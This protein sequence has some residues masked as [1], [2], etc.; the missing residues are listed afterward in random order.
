MQVAN[1]YI[2]SQFGSSV[3]SYVSS[4]LSSAGS[5]AAIGT[6]IAPG[7]GT[8]VGAALGGLGGLLTAHTEQYAEQDDVFKSYVQDAA[9]GALQER[10]DAIASGSATAAQREQD[11]IAF[12]RLLGD[13]IGS[14][15][16]ED[17]RVL[18]ASTPM[19]YSDLTSMSRALAT[20]FGESPDRMLELME[21]I[22]DAGSAIGI[23]ASGMTEMARSLSRME[24]SGKATLE[25]LNIFQDRG[26]DVIG[27]LSNGLGKTQDEIYDMISKSEIRGVDAVNIIQRAMEDM[28][29]GA[30]EKQSQTF[31]GL[32][33][34]LS[35]A[36]TEMENAYGEG[37]NE[38]RKAGLQAEID[39]L[40]GESGEM[41][42]EANRAIGAF[43]AEQENE[44]ERMIRAAQKDVM[45][46]VDYK[47]L[48]AQGTDE[49][50]AEAGMLLMAAK[51]QG[52][53]KYNASDGAQ[54]LLASEEA[55]VGK[56][57]NN[58]SL[59]DQYW[60]AGY[61]KGIWYSKGR[62]AA[63]ADTGGAEAYTTEEDWLQA[64]I[65]AG[66][67]QSHAY[68]LQRVPYDNYPALLHEGERVLTASEAR[69]ADARQAAS[70]LIT[71]N[72]FS[73]REEADIDRIA[74][75]LA[76]KLQAAMM[77]GVR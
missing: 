64:S 34:T 66:R 46:T 21:A 32:T 60:N 52:Q 73:V 15:Y 38:A 23:D 47:N 3:G 1:T 36:Q 76:E 30:M 43:Y 72:T 54:L 20:G 29:D 28:Y 58:T 26:V 74:G 19:E 25:Y 6:A 2:E 18:A 65:Q 9:T 63:M 71:G 48:M 10:A 35:D 62:A 11:E 61:R 49:A 24:S 59:D 17:L 70:V 12:N 57:Q 27:M 5:G 16:L 4:A 42:Q 67:G 40:T 22:G 68:G 51:I 41:M 7:I 50:Y 56:I 31:L 37:Y 69:R 39:Y 44:R 55:L 45:E 75:A 53:N 8:V 13:G 33:S 14:R 77:T